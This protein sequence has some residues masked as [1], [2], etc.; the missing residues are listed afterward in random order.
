MN[1]EHLGKLKKKK[2]SPSIL[3]N[4]VFVGLF[5]SSKGTFSPTGQP[6]MLL[7]LEEKSS[8][9]NSA[10]L[11]QVWYNRKI[12]PSVVRVVLLYWAPACSIANL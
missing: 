3:E 4:G 2:S 6:F 9:A 7:V 8:T 11:L 12:S 1:F 5:F 10:V